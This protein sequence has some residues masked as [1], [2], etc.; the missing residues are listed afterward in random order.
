MAHFLE[1]LLAVEEQ[2]N[3]LLATAESCTGG[4]IASAITDIAGSSAIFDR[5]F[6]TYSNAAKSEILGVPAE[7]INQRG[8]VSDPVAK[9]MAEGALAHSNA[10][11]SISTT[12]IAGPEGGSKEKPVG[13]VWIGLCRKGQK[14]TAQCFLFE[15]NRAAVRQQ[16]V[17]K[18]LEML[19]HAIA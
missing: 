8:A 11:L 14:A 3:I 13:T 2:P 1:T 12:G 19:Q 10:N 5:G 15:G 7:L 9:A 18:A 16:A 6:V 4:L 17:N